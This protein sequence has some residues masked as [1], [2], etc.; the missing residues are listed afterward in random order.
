M[1]PDRFAELLSASSLSDDGYRHGYRH[2]LRRRYHGALYD[3]SPGHA[4][5]IAEHPEADP[6]R[7]RA[8]RG[9][10]DG[11]AGVEPEIDSRS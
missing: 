1:T 5:W 6:P 7:Q 2:G 4:Y 3:P 9:Y 11:L 8:L 10:R